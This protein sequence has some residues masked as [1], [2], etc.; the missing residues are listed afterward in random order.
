MTVPRFIMA[1]FIASVLFVSPAVA[2]EEPTIDG[3]LYEMISRL[4]KTLG[5]LDQ[6]DRRVARIENM[7]LPIRLQPDKHG[8]IRD[9]SGRPVGVWGIVYPSIEQRARR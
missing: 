3:G 9:A 5:R 7:L 2:A 6:I 8:T 1:C 4:D